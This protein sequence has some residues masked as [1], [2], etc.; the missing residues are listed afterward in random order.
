MHLNIEDLNAIILCGA[1]IC[2]DF[3]LV[4][5]PENTSQSNQTNVPHNLPSLNTN[6]DRK[7]L[8][9]FVVDNPELEQ[10]EALLEQFNIF[11]AIGV[12][13][14]ELRHSDFLA[15]LLN[16][17]ENHGL[18]DVFLKRLLQ[19]ILVATQDVI[20]QITPIDLDVWSLDQM[21]VLREWQN[22]DI[23]LLDEA[24][25]LAII[26]EN[27]INISEHSNQ[28]LRY[29]CQVHQHYPDCNIIGLYLTPD[30][31]SP[32]DKARETYLPVDYSL[33]CK[34][35]ESLI[36]NRAST[37]GTDVVTLIRH[38]TQMLRRHIVSE[39]DI[40]ELCH[41]I[42]QKHQRA[43]DLIY[44]HRPDQ[45]ATIQTILENLIHKT[46]DLAL[47]DPDAH[48]KR[49]IRFVVQEWKNAPKLEEEGKGWT[50][51][52]R[53][54]LFEF[55]NAVD[56]LMLRLYIGPGPKETRLRLFNMATQ[57]KPLFQPAKAL[58][59]KWNSIFQRS[60]LRSEDYEDAGDDELEAE[61]RKYWTAFLENDL[62]K[63]KSALKAEDWIWQSANTTSP[64]QG[65]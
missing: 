31:E 15:F 4:K 58:K 19:K 7:A 29:H 1:C 27:K 16:P 56:S 14:Q 41:R 64:M 60:F 40:A 23:L 20:V 3:K 62:P 10:L 37:L 53:I 6:V 47:D 26:I 44:E 33:V 50:P 13:R 8:E 55:Q 30:G 49:N 17:Q 45:Q 38:Y 42:Y 9:A 24:H 32:K 25:K 11:E 46:A 21:L 61:I 59:N 51:S 54:L 28:L 52:H 22:I 36:E 5:M 63:I 39:S 57:K 2:F 35:L 65:G 43:L 18:G 48:L 12:V 34:V